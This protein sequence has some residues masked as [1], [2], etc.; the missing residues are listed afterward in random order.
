MKVLVTVGIPFYNA[1][2]YLKYSIQSVLNQTYKNFELILIDDGSNDNSLSIANSFGD[3]RIKVISDGE[4]KG[5]VYRLNQ[6]TTIANGKF[7]ARMDADDIM[8]YNRISYQVVFLE[9]HPNVDVVGSAY[10]SIDCNNKIMGKVTPNLVPKSLRSI[11][12][13]GAFAHPTVM[14]KTE[15]FRENQY[16]IIWTRMEDLELWL[17]TVAFSNFR[18]LS[19]PLLFYRNVGVP[20][21]NKYIKSNIG[22]IKLLRQTKKYNISF[23]DSVFFI[24]SNLL[25]IAVYFLFS[26]SGKI[27]YLLKKRSVPIYSNDEKV[28]SEKIL[29]M[30][31]DVCHFK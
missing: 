12:S 9:T 15:W 17:R 7:Y 11:L 19:E 29:N 22:I 18:N 25:K 20:T 24:I 16:D 30:S 26:I 27:D 14:G 4:N 5:L 8:H 3:E 31:V 6:L 10:Y 13:K 28:L 23:I 2:K 21:L 1:E